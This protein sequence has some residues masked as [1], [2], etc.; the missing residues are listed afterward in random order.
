MNDDLA[1]GKGAAQ[2]VKEI[3]GAMDSTAS[4]DYNYALG[5]IVNSQPTINK[6]DPNYRSQ[7]IGIEDF[8]II[9]VIG[10]GSFGKVYLVQKKDDNN[11]YAMKSL[12]KDMVLRKGQTTNTRGKP[13][14]P[15]SQSTL[16]STSHSPCL[17]V[18]TYCSRKDDP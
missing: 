11:I 10:R 12:K 2:Q 3:K 18:P 15:P 9:R 1:G 14:F 5:S 8:K 16:Y 6:N 13:P 17:F 4:S 7:D